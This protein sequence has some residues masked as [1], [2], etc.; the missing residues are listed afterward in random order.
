VLYWRVTGGRKLRRP[1]E[2]K[3]LKIHRNKCF[4][5]VWYQNQCNALI[6]NKHFKPCTYT[7]TLVNA[8]FNLLLTSIHNSAA[9]LCTDIQLKTPLAPRHVVH[10]NEMLSY[11]C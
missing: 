1:R 8:L 6:N 3:G 11:D 5:G 9:Q 2:R 4:I 10:N 7:C